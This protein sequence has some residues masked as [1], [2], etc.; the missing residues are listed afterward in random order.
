MKHLENLFSLYSGSEEYDQLG[1]IPEVS[2]AYSKIKACMNRMS[3][4]EQFELNDLIVAH[5]AAN[6][7]Q[8][9]IYGFRYAMRLKVDCGLIEGGGCMMEQLKT[10]CQQYGIKFIPIKAED[11]QYN[12]AIICKD[13]VMFVDETL[14][15]EWLSVLL[16]HTEKALQTNPP[17]GFVQFSEAGMPEEW[18]RGGADHDA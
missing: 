15:D 2:N 9:F 18:Q 4:D 1:E 7:K 11:V 17:G 8:G 3:K 10:F 13:G 6:E 16:P 12:L 5:G 14:T